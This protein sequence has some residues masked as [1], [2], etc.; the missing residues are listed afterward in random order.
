MTS[1]QYDAITDALCFLHNFKDNNFT[2]CFI[3]EDRAQQVI[4]KLEEAI[5]QDGG[6]GMHGIDK[7]CRGPVEY[8]P[9]KKKA[10][11]FSG[12]QTF[13]YSIYAS[14]FPPASAFAF[15][16]KKGIERYEKDLKNK[17][18]D[19]VSKIPAGVVRRIVV[20]CDIELGD[21]M[22]NTVTWEPT[23]DLKCKKEEVKNKRSK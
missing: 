21:T 3:R 8:K 13:S 2:A 6:I 22:R 19:Y 17:V 10:V 12:R 20:R 5:K 11:C 15:T 16:V 7:G 18:V 1:S 14:V 4:E 9:C 23:E